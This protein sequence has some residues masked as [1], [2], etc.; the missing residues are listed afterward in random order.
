MSLNG[1]RHREQESRH[2]THTHTHRAQQ[3]KKREGAEHKQS[4]CC[5]Q[6]SQQQICFSVLSA[7]SLLTIESRTDSR[8]QTHIS[9]SCSDAWLNHPLTV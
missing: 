8:E 7:V 4:L 6:L 3:Q 5:Q 9:S 1:Q 2:S